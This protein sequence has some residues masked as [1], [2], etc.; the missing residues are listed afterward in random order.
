MTRAGCPTFVISLTVVAFVATG[1]KRSHGEARSRT[2][3]SR[4]ASQRVSPPRMGAMPAWLA[5][6]AA[7]PVGFA[8]GWNARW[9]GANDGPEPVGELVAV[10]LATGTL[11]HAEVG[12]TSPPRI[13]GPNRL[14]FESTPGHASCLTGLRTRGASP[15]ETSCH[16]ALVDVPETRVVFDAAPAAEIAG[17]GGAQ[18]RW[19]ARPEP[20]SAWDRVAVISREGE[21]VGLEMHTFRGT[22]QDVQLVL[23]RG[24]TGEP[25]ARIEGVSTSVLCD[26]DCRTSETVRASE[27][28]SPHHV[29]VTVPRDY[30]P[31]ARIPTLLALHGYR[32]EPGVF[33]DDPVWQR[34]ADVH[35]IAIVAIAATRVDA[36]RRYAWTQ[37]VLIDAAH[38]ASA[39]A[40]VRARVAVDDE[41]VVLIG[42]SQGADVGYRLLATYP[43]TFRGLVAASIGTL[44]GAPPLPDGGSPSLNG[45]T[46]ITTFG[47]GEPLG[48][49]LNTEDLVARARA[50][51]ARVVTRAVERQ[52]EHAL[53]ADVEDVLP[54]WLATID[55]AFARTSR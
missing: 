7:D 50:R 27:P 51:G 20:G 12:I 11:C 38:I 48:A 5:S 24:R 30:A 31:P 42:F 25:I 39:I 14:C 55:P 53:P 40:S 49:R 47:A 13:D 9:S 41:H 6:C 32:G 22:E 21:V 44:E 29:R 17:C 45:H 3:T 54:G 19:S 10:A 1:C 35:R 33:A 43:E 34:I 26:P 4:A 46:V 23:F 37:D 16:V 28:G 36:P 2:S 15:H 18:A 8:L 52:R